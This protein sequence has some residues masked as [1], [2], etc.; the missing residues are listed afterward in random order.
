MVSTYFMLP[1]LY[2]IMVEAI[3]SGHV[4]HNRCQAHRQARLV[5]CIH[6]LAPCSKLGLRYQPLL[7]PPS[8]SCQMLLHLACLWPDCRC[9]TLGRTQQQLSASLLMPRCSHG[10]PRAQHPSA[11]ACKH[12]MV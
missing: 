12:A 4:C 8:Q 9:M 5:H 3:Y 10:L 11:G 7:P 2:M 6:R 1:A